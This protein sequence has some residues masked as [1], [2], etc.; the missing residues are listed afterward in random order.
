MNYIS[1]ILMATYA[2]EFK[3]KVLCVCMFNERD[4]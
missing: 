2:I 3:G 4:V 1:A